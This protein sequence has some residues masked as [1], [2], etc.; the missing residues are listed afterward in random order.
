MSQVEVAVVA[1]H[2]GEA[3]MGLRCPSDEIGPAWNLPGIVDASRR[4]TA[5]AEFEQPLDITGLTRRLVAGDPQARPAAQSPNGLGDGERKAI[6]CNAPVIIENE[7]H[8]GPTVERR[9]FR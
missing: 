2:Q 1:R 8:L 9:Q 4:A 7:R 3:D 5:A 6:G